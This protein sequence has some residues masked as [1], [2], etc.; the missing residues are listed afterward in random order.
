MRNRPC[1]TAL[2]YLEGY[3]IIPCTVQYIVYYVYYVYYV[4]CGTKLSYLRLP[5]VIHCIMCVLRAMY[6]YQWRKGRP[7]ALRDKLRGFLCS[8]DAKT[9]IIHFMSVY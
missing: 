3:S 6:N 9:Y 5:C 1:G 2:S 7:A 8:F 4:Y